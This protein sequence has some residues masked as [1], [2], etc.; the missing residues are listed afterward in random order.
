MSRLFLII[1]SLLLVTV[2]RADITFGQ[3]SKIS[4]TPDYLEGNFS[5]KKY[6][7]VLDAELTS[8]GQFVYKKGVFLRWITTEPI[9]NEFIMTPSKLAENPATAVLSEILFAV[10]TA[11]WQKLSI[12]FDLSGK[13]ESK[14]WDVELIP[15]DNIVAQV[16]SRVEIRGD[17]WLREIIL[18]EMD[19]D[20]ITIKLDNHQQ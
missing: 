15:V 1:I 16:V 20:H 19:G 7:Q 4:A 6:L 10:L 13:V 18:H 14:Q 5:Q 3:L 2:A 12:Y 8:T 11:E 17:T 9:Q